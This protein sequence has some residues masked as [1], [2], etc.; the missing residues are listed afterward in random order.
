MP[1]KRM[2]I[3][4]TA[5]THYL[6]GKF[7]RKAINAQIL[8]H[9]KLAFPEMVFLASHV[10]AETQPLYNEGVDCIDNLPT[11]VR[12]AKKPTPWGEIGGG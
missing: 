3:V 9:A 6:A 8:D 10:E 5:D 12:K 2:V 11:R 1:V 4:I 7:D